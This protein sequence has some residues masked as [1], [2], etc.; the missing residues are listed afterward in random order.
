MVSQA[1]NAAECEDSAGIQGFLW[2][3]AVAKGGIGGV[4]HLPLSSSKLK[5]SQ[6]SWSGRSGPRM[7]VIEGDQYFSSPG[8]VISLYSGFSSSFW[9]T[10]NPNKSIIRRSPSGVF[11]FCYL[12]EGPSESTDGQFPEF[13][14]YY[15]RIYSQNPQ[16]NARN[17]DMRRM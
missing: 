5:W 1:S 9:I 7:L 14:G 11:G 13:A 16:T 15:Q 6:A 10:N 17:V 4:L 8:I 12:F 2:N 3:S